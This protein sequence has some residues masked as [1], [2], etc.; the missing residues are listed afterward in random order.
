MSKVNNR[1]P[2]GKSWTWQT[3]NFKRSDAWRTAGINVRR[4]IDFLEIEQMQKRGRENGW[5]KAPRRQ[6]ED[7]GIAAR[8]VSLAIDDAIARGLIDRKRGQGRT[9]NT[10]ALTWLPLADDTPASDR[11]QHY[12]ESGKVLRRGIRREVA[13]GIRREVTKPV[14]VSEGKSQ[15]PK[16]RV[17]E[18]K[19]PSRG[20]Y[21]GGAGNSDLS[22]AAGDAAVPPTANGVT[23]ALTPV[24]DCA[25]AAPNSPG[26]PPWR[27]SCR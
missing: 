5:L 20:S 12:T 27:S 10:Y 8:H 24:A 26:T 21:Q 1:P 4:L 14:G 19:H 7:Y 16:T 6:L 17:S 18:G 9:P 3:L 22:G 23:P 2:V 15:S 25:T 13:K 11:W